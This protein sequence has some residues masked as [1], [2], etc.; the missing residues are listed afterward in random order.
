MT[1]THLS[2]FATARPALALAL[3]RALRSVW[4]ARRDARGADCATMHDLASN[5]ILSIAKPLGTFVECLQG[6]VWIT[7][8]A[9]RRDIV[10]AAGQTFTADRDDRSLIQA[11]AFSR[12]RLSLARPAS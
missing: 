3:Y 10:L 12:V 7:I 2:N 6:C 5:Q 9:D 4:S 8:D 11:L 1:T